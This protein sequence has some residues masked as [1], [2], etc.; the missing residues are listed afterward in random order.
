V[1]QKSFQNTC[2]ITVKKVHPVT[3]HKVMGALELCFLNLRARGGRRSIPC[4][5]HLTPG[6][7]TQYPLYRRLGEPQD[8]SEWVQRILPPPELEPPPVQP[9][10]CYTSYTITASI[11]TGSS[12]QKKRPEWVNIYKSMTAMSL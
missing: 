7:K 5:S 10:C 8:Q 11:I 6:N 12:R 1:L 9:I 4:L 2:I 3:C